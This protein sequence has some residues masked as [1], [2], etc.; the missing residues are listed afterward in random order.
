MEILKDL[1]RFIYRIK[2]ARIWQIRKHAA[3]LKFLIEIYGQG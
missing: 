2:E 3:Q 1:L